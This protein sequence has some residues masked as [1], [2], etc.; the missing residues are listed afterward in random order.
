MHPQ[1]FI[2]SLF[3]LIPLAIGIYLIVD[4]ACLPKEDEDEPVS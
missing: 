1:I 4:Y 3:L 2:F